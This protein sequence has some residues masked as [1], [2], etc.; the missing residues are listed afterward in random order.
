M[1]ESVRVCETESDCKRVFVCERERLRQSEREREREGGGERERE[2]E[3]ESTWGRTAAEI[4]CL[5]AIRST[6]SL[7]AHGPY[8]RPMPSHGH[9]AHI[10]RL[11]IDKKKV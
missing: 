7:L 8:H 10:K 1:R 3:G 4:S 11:P 2:R 6:P 9:L 5:S